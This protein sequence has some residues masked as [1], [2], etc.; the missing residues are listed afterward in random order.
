MDCNHRRSWLSGHV[1][2]H[3]VSNRVSNGNKNQRPRSCHNTFSL[4]TD[5]EAS[6]MVCQKFFSSTLGYSS[7]RVLLELID[8]I[9]VNSGIPSADHRGKNS[10]PN[11]SDHDLISEHIESYHP[12]LSHY[13]RGHAP[14]RQHITY[15]TNLKKMH[16]DF[17]E[18]QLQLNTHSRPSLLPWTRWGRQPF[19]QHR[20]GL[21]MITPL[22][23][24]FRI[25]WRCYFLSILSCYH[26]V[27]ICIDHISILTY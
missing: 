14:L 18:K 21:G 2:T 6:V 24:I 5:T 16:A 26:A 27:P 22:T 8:N 4:Q 20:C 1:Q 3:L 15:E 13:T 17:I 19:Q 12:L 7:H 10:L 25:C 23:L 11:K 9:R